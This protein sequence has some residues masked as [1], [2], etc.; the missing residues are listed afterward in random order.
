MADF[1]VKWKGKLAMKDGLAVNN[2]TADARRM[3][4]AKFVVVADKI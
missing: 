1:F 4:G 3:Y 2:Q